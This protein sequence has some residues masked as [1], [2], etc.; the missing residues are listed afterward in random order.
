MARRYPKL[1][2]HKIVRDRKV[3]LKESISRFSQ[4]FVIEVFKKVIIEGSCTAAAKYIEERVKERERER[5][6]RR[7]Q[8]SRI[9][10][11]LALSPRGC[12]HRVSAEARELP[13]NFLVE[14]IARPQLQQQQRQQHLL[15]FAWVW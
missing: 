8:N 12:S 9:S 11:T 2:I 15:S 5:E 1:N 6:R 10:P 7:V 4:H 13:S 14:P 3:K